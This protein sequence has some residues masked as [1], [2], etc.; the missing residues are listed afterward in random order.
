MIEKTKQ[1]VE[2]KYTL[3][4]GY[5]GDAKVRALWFFFVMPLIQSKRAIPITDVCVSLQVIY[6]DTD[7]VM[8][9]LGVKTVTEAME[10]GREAA[11]WVSSHFTPPIK[12]EF[13]KVCICH[14]ASISELG[15]IV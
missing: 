6:G 2:S 3:A 10:I 5:K 9:K 4:N 15:H 13:E 1:L 11:E 14:I 12:L 7:S 8:C